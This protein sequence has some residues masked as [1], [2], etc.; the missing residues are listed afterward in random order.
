MMD[1]GTIKNGPFEID[2]QCCSGCSKQNNLFGLDQGSAVR[3]DRHR[4]KRKNFI[5]WS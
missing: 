2:Y 1:D 4:K 3:G 5:L